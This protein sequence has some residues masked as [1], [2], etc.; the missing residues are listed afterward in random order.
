LPCG[1]KPPVTLRDTEKYAS[2]KLQRIRKSAYF[3]G[4]MPSLGIFSSQVLRT[5]CPFTSEQS[6]SFIVLLDLPAFLSSY[7]AIAQ[8]TPVFRL[9][10]TRPVSF[11]PKTFLLFYQS[12]LFVIMS[13]HSSE[14]ANYHRGRR[15]KAQPQQQFQWTQQL[16]TEMP[17]GYS[18][19]DGY[20]HMPPSNEAF[21]SMDL[22]LPML[23]FNL[24]SGWEHTNLIQYHSQSSIVP[25]TNSFLSVRDTSSVV[26]EQATNE[27]TNLRMRSYSEASNRISDTHSD[28]FLSS[29]HGS[30]Q[31]I[32]EGWEPGADYA[33]ETAEDGMY[34][35]H[36]QGAM[37]TDMSTPG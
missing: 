25:S 13:G 31:G 15:P 23:G 29:V 20:T 5:P 1:V 2:V 8:V 22:D 37:L 18:I 24:P 16:H 30:S 17:N 7:L 9:H 21:E 28:D 4:K 11:S 33:V 35:T 12:L 36:S 10:P 26:S 27:W 32:P 34:M 3:V 19:P 6:P 14:E